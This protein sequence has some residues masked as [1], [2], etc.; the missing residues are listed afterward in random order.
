MTRAEFADAVFVYCSIMGASVTSWI[1][2]EEHNQ[3]VGGVAHSAHVAG[4]AVDV[5]YRTPWATHEGQEWAERLGL[6][7]IREQDHDHLQPLG[8]KAG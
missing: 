6:L 7:L 4:L 2:T 1:R 8:W 3:E 5:V